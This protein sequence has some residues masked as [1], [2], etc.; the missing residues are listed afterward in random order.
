MSTVPPLRPHPAA[1][2]LTGPEAALSVVLTA[3]S[4]LGGPGTVVLLLDAHHRGIGCVVIVG[5]GRLRPVAEMVLHLVGL[6]PGIQAL[7]LASHRGPRGDH[8][9]T[10]HERQLFPALRAVFADAGVDLVDWF[11]TAGERASSVCE[12]TDGDPHW[13]GAGAGAPLDG[14]APDGA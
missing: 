9:P 1:V 6:E 7:V 14:G 5:A 4:D 8:V 2:P 11:V 13:L 10:P 12:L 3:A